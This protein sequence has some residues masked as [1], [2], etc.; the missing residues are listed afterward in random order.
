M[1]KSIVLGGGCFWCL[2]AFY[3]NIR[4]VESVTCG[5]AGGHTDDPTYRS[6]CSETTGHAEV[7]EILYDESTV[8]EKV[9]LDVFW[10]CHNPT[11]L[12]RQG[13]DEGESYRSIL[14]YESDEQN[15]RFLV[16]RDTAQSLWDDKIVTE[17]K[18]LDRFYAAEPEHQNYFENHPE[19]A[20]CQ[21]VI[22]PKLNELKRSFADLL[23]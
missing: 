21:I 8:S 6:V 5:Y 19:A 17:I 1:Q 12:N 10:A 20:Y 15:K 13:H 3:E 23:E 9:L 7:V 11:T 14:L 16:S 4:G 22:S 2:D 18:Q